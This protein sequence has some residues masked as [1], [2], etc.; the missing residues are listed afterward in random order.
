M[1][2]PNPYKQQI[3]DKKRDLP[4]DPIPDVEYP[5]YIYGRYF[6]TKEQYDEALHEFLNGY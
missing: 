4:S 5:K 3:L 2:N 6:E 1:T